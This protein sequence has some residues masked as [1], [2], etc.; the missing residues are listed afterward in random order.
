[1]SC[2]RDDIGQVVVVDGLS[3]SILAL[4]VLHFV[5][6][7][8]ALFV[9]DCMGLFSS[10]GWC[11]RLA[12]SLRKRSVLIQLERRTTIVSIKADWFACSGHSCK[13]SAAA[14]VALVVEVDPRDWLDGGT[15]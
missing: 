10:T 5:L 3:G 15:S 14:V 6:A 9:V 2:C 4:L 12:H 11:P 1:M 13:G 8:L 7:L